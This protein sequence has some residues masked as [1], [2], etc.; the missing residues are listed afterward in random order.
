[1]DENRKK[2]LALETLDSI[3]GTIRNS[4][5]K[6]ASLMTI[7]GIVFG[8]SAFSINELKDKTNC[9]QNICIYIFG[10]MYV[11]C[12]IAL[13]LLLIL[14][15]LPRRKKRH[16]IKNKELYFKN[17]GEDVQ[18]S[19]KNKELDSLIYK[20]T[21]LEVVKDQI[22]I[23]SRISHIKE[24]MLRIA[25]WVSLVLVVCLAAL[26]VLAFLKI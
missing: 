10:I 13:M 25:I 21:P 12:F 18:R 1:M 6:A 17:Y 2:E 20:E 8:L 24:N 23:C 5:V 7:A 4:N 14:T 9:A 22:R 16:E 15:I 19:I 26:L 3:Q 11:V